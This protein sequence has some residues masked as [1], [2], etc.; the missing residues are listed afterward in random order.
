MFK[1]TA[2]LLHDARYIADEVEAAVRAMLGDRFGYARRDLGQAVTAAEVIAAL[3]TVPGVVSVDLDELSLYSDADLPDA[4]L[5]VAQILRARPA[6]VETDTAGVQTLHP[7]ELLTLL[8]S[9]ATLTLE[10]E[11]V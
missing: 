1:L 3:Q 5:V 7:A 6:R 2:T 4:P 10:A 11:N 9:S 8:S